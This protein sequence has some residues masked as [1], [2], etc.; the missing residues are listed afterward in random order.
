MDDI[1]EE[2]KREAEAELDSLIEQYER[3]MKNDIPKPK[4][5]IDIFLMQIGILN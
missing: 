3:E 5:L 4:T 2:M 1:D